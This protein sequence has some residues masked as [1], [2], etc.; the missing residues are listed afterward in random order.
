MGVTGVPAIIFAN[1]IAVA[2]AREPDVLIAAI[3]KV[4]AMGEERLV[5]DQ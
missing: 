2:G 4:L 3:D 5:E 1:R